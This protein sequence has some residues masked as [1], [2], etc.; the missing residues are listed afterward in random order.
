MVEVNAE[1]DFV[2]RNETFQD[3]VADRR[4]D[5]ARRSARTSRRS[6]PR[7]IPA[8]S[9]TVADELTHL[10]ATIGEN[11]TMRRAARAVGEA[12]R[13]RDLRAQRAASPASARSAC[14]SRVEGAERTRRAGNARPPGRHARRRDPPRGARRRRRRPRRAGAR[15][16]RAH[17]AGP[18][19]RQA[20]GHH[21][22]DGR[23]PHPQILRGSRA[24]GAG[25]GA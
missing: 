3:F 8:P 23:R 22:E 25:L 7:R 15:T 12:G 1:T 11:M 20:R 18:R 5:R 6:R 10:V 13:G 9:R 17:R 2:A 14:W 16:R 4:R 19:L 21:R 24:A